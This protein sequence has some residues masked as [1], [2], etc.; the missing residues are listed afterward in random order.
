MGPTQTGN[1]SETDR[2]L[3]SVAEGNREIWGDLLSRHRERLHTMVSLRLDPRLKGRIDPSDVIQEAFL[4]ASIQLNDYLKNPSMPFFLWLRAVTGQRLIALHRHHL[5]K[6]K[7]DAGRE[8]PLYP[9]AFP[10]ASSAALAAQLLGHALRP[11]QVA[12]QAEFEAKVHE[13]LDQMD[14]LDREILVLRHFEQ[15]SN[16]ESAQVLD[17]GESAASK[18]YIRALRRL[19]AILMEMPGGIE[20]LLP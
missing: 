3:Q 20:E 6:Q 10:E 4:T 14:P 11:S 9:R 15:L 19:K 13:V 1:S 2:L 18:R 5:G 12:M 8:I 16:T 17:L 7:R